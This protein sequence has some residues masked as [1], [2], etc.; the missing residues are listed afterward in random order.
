MYGFA[1]I[2]VAAAIA[3][4]GEHR[5][6][7]SISPI[8]GKVRERIEGSSW[9]PGCPVGLGKLRLLGLT[10]RG[11]DG[12]SRH[13]RLVVHRRHADEIVS[14][15]KRLYAIDFPI[16]RMELVDRYGADD[17][18]SMRADNTSAFN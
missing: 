17:Q 9:R 8:E 6:D 16:R 15:F 1:T 18:R 4:G 3:G 10:Y 11:F 12:D 13:G 7:A 5:F 14:V 2:I